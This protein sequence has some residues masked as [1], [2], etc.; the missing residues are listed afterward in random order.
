MKIRK[1]TTIA[2]V[3]VLI[4]GAA[5]TSK[6]KTA[7][8]KTLQ[9]VLDSI[10]VQLAQVKDAAKAV[11]QIKEVL[12]SEGKITK[13]TSNRI[14]K[15]LITVDTV[16]KEMNTKLATYESFTP[17]ARDDLAKLYKDLESAYNDLKAA[18]IFPANSGVDKAFLIGDA[19]FAGLGIFFK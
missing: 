9:P 7:P 15:T 16:G 1:A 5:C 10:A 12:L 3:C 11:R 4:A 14:T 18:G 6:V 8:G 17:T 2:L 13:A 19:A